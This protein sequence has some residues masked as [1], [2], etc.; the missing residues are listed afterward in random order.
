MTYK[1]LGTLIKFS[2]KNN[3]DELTLELIKN[4]N[5]EQRCLLGHVIRS[6]DQSNIIATK[7]EKET[8][9][10]SKYWDYVTNKNYYCVYDF[11]KE[12]E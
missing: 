6:Y 8:L 4:L 10:R 7:L 1:M 11:L 9:G 2:T 12:L 5:N 3:H